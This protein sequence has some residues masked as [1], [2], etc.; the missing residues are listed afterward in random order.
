[1]RISPHV[2]RHRPAAAPLTNI[3]HDLETI[4]AATKGSGRAFGSTKASLT[5]IIQDLEAIRTATQGSGP[6]AARRW[7]QE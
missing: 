2:V 7:E 6:A 1:M 5:S 3:I 4:L